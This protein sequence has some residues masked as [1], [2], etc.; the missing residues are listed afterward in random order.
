MN[1]AAELLGID[2]C[3]KSAALRRG[4]RVQDEHGRVGVVLAGRLSVAGRRVGNDYEVDWDD[5][6][7]TWVEEA[8]LLSAVEAKGVFSCASV[9]SSLIA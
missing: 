4:D 9:T 2:R 7:T 8:R 5:G 6:G 1:I 3:L